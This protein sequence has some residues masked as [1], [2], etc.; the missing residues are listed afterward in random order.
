MLR[1]ATERD[2]EDIRRWRNHD[3]VRKASI[4][5]DEIT[6]EGH[7]RWWAGVQADP[8]RRVLVFSYLG[9]PSGVVLINNHDPVART[10]EWGFFLDVDGLDARGQLLP[11]WIQL[12]K[13]AVAYGFDELG[14]QAMGGRT[15]ASNDRVLA[16]HRRFGFKDVPERTYSTSIDGVIQTVVWTELTANGRPPSSAR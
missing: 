3:K 14:L 5:T 13:E 8:A 1:E 15:L 2:L 9:T 12:E 10:A 7:A 16:L 6:P 11:A 4:F